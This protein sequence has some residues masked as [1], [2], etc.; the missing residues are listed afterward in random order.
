MNFGG[1]KELFENATEELNALLS[2]EDSALT[3]NFLSRLCVRSADTKEAANKSQ[4]TFP[5]Q[6]GD[7]YVLLMA[8]MSSS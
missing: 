6:D 4:I 7:E 8:P 2:E 5:L 1:R 3:S